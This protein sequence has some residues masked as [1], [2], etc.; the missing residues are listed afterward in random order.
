M[1]S[2]AAE[3]L[4]SI[5]KD[6][7]KLDKDTILLDVCCGTGTIGLCMAKEVK[8]VVGVEIVAEAVHDARNNA[9]LNGIIK[10]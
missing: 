1:N 6:W 9:Q 10:R 5:L 8:K 3:I 7:A 4:F 2:S